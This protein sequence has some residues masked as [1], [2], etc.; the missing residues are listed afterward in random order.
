MPIFSSRFLP[1]PHPS[2]LP[3]SP[4]PSLLSEAGGQLRRKWMDGGYAPSGGEWDD[5]D[6]LH[7]EQDLAAR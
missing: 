3:P 4:S 2:S 6:T 5:P 7:F 1:T